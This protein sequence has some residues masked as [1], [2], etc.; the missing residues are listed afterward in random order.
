LPEM[1]REYGH[2]RVYI[3]EVCQKCSWNHLHLSY[4]LGDGVPRTPPRAPRDVL[5]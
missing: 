2:F 5:E 4:I 1:A 3:V